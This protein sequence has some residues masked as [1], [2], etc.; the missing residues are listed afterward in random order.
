VSKLGIFGGT[1][2]PI[3]LGHL[4]TAQSV[5]ELRKLEKILFIPS[6]ISPHK[7][8]QVITEGKHRLKMIE[9]AIEGNKYF[10]VSDFEI[11]KKN[12][13]YTVD[14]L[15]ELS[16]KNKKIELIIGID[17]LLKFGTWKEPDKI[18]KLAKLV[19]L[20]RRIGEEKI[21]KNKYYKT[22]DFVET[23][24]IEISSSEI[25]ERVKNNLSVDFLVPSKVNQYIQKHNLYRD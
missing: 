14:T 5:L 18:L 2:D 6:F 17:N 7:T 15:Y 11:R 12:I 10:E 25:R 8:D 19:V 23:P 1:F 3:H 9:L 4:I 21:R 22:A 24:L 13:S 20:K 16:G